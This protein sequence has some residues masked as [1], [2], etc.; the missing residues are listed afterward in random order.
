MSLQT[1]T[2]AH[3]QLTVATAA[4][5]M[6][7][8]A[9]NESLGQ[10]Y[11]TLQMRENE[12]GEVRAAGRQW[13]VEQKGLVAAAVTAG[14][15]K[16]GGLIDV[17][18]FSVI[19]SETALTEEPRQ[20]LLAAVNHAETALAGIESGARELTM[21]RARRASLMTGLGVAALVLIVLAGS[22]LFGPRVRD[23]AMAA[24]VEAGLLSPTSV[25]TET[26][27]IETPVVTD[28]QPEN[29]ATTQQPTTQ[30]VPVTDS[31][32][33]ES[34]TAVAQ[35]PEP[36]SDS[37]STQTGAAQDP[38]PEPVTAEDATESASVGETGARDSADVESLADAEPTGDAIAPVPLEGNG[39]IQL[40]FSPGA[41]YTP[42]LSP[43]QTRL[44]FASEVGDRWQLMEA[45]VN[46]EGEPE[47]LVAG[48]FNIYAPEFSPDGLTL[49]AVANI[50]GDLDI[51]Q[52]DA[53]T[54]EILAQVTDFAGQEHSPRWLPDGSGFIFTAEE[55]GDWAVYAADFD[56]NYDRLA[57][58][59]NFD[60]FAFP[61]PDGGHIAFYS[62][63]D[64]D[65]E[66]YLMG[67]DGQ[68]PLRLTS[69]RGRD[70]ANDFS[71]DGEWI[72]F[73]SDRDGDYEIFVIRPDGTGIRQLT[74]NSAGDWVPSFSPDGQWLLFQS[75]RSGN[76]DIYRMPFDP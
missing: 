41:D 18:G 40:T 17:E 4:T 1:F 33:E 8:A 32:T 19:A 65:Y 51:Y 69:N 54:G 47:T 49:L 22:F 62:G 13:A 26:T 30:I 61:S 20:G 60:G 36:E 58:S 53:F 59:G 24:A 9:R 55:D 66:I 12:A 23:R 42:T 39:V 63:R 64:D 74:D 67:I 15:F 34:Q 29:Q 50:D 14:R 31:A 52:L 43:D 25:P 56:G 2:T 48:S 71:P 37:E 21:W 35:D 28:E 44:I 11:R 5:Q 72:A 6:A 73:E 3:P 16:A 38:V 46:G 45:S 10:A 76:M 75:D 7:F 70:A 57:N 68:N 27:A